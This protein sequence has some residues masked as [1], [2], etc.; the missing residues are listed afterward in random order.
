MIKGVS[1]PSIRPGQDKNIPPRGLDHLGWHWYNLISYFL[2]K[3]CDQSRSKP[4]SPRPMRHLTKSPIC[5]S[6]HLPSRST[7]WGRTAKAGRLNCPTWSIQVNIQAE[8]NTFAANSELRDFTKWSLWDVPVDGSR[9][10]SVATL[11]RKNHEQLA[12]RFKFFKT[13]HHKRRRTLAW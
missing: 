6:W 12:W 10:F 8:G 11:D 9:L 13:A 5:V 4:P 7:F 1:I 3:T 2:A